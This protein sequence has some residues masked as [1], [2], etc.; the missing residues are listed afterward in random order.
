VGFTRNLKICIIIWKGL[1]KGPQNDKIIFVW[2]ETV[3]TSDGFL[4]RPYNFF[5]CIKLTRSKVSKK[6]ALCFLIYFLRAQC[7]RAQCFHTSSNTLPST[8]WW[9]MKP[10]IELEMNKF[11]KASDQIYAPFNMQQRTQKSVCFFMNIFWLLLSWI[12][13]SMRT[14][15]KN[16]NKTSASYIKMLLASQSQHPS[17][18]R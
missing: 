17:I 6:I 18:Y 15:A 11:S 7:F 9:K 8:W 1:F 10:T 16:I 3:L 4:K 12:C 2:T 5:L 13:L 14:H